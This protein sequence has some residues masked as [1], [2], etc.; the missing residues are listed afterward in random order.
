MPF[1]V[2]SPPSRF[3]VY[4][5]VD[6]LITCDMITENDFVL[7]WEANA[8]DDSLSFVTVEPSALGII[9]E[10][11]ATPNG[12][13]TKVGSATTVTMNWNAGQSRWEPNSEFLLDDGAF[14]LFEVTLAVT[15]K[16]GASC[17]YDVEYPFLYIDLGTVPSASPTISG[18]QQV[19][20]LLTGT[21]NYFSPDGIPQDVP[22]TVRRWYSYTDAGGSIGET[23]IGTGSTYT[24]TSSETN[25]YIRYKVTPAAQSG[26]SPGFEYSSTVFGMVVTNIP[27]YSGSTTSASTFTISQTLASAETIIIDWGDG[28]K[29]VLS[30]TTGSL[31][32]FSRTYAG[33]G[34]KNFFVYETATNVRAVSMFSKSLTGTLDISTCTGINTLFVY[35][36]SALT[37]ISWPVATWSDIRTYGCS[38]T[39]IVF[40][41]GTVWNNTTLWV[42]NSTVT[43]LDL[44]NTTGTMTALVCEGSSITSLD[45][46]TFNFSTVG[47]F[48]VSNSTLL[49]TINH[50][51]TT[52]KVYR[53]WAQNTSIE[54]LTVPFDF[55]NIVAAIR[56]NNNGSLASVNFLGTGTVNEF[57]CSACDLSTLDVSMFTVAASTQFTVRDNPSLSSITH[58][59][60][61]SGAF[62]IYDNSI[63]SLGFYSLGG[64]KFTSNVQAAMNDNAMTAA[65]VNQWLDSMS[66]AGSGEDLLPATGT[67]TIIIGGTN[68]APDSSSGGFDGVAAA[69][70]IS[71][72]GYILTT[73]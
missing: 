4:C 20:E 23:L 28:T 17:S 21:D 30:A 42:S 5:P 7:S 65:E 33:S 15:L 49:A 37:S 39:D 62:R 61:P 54:T 63:C 70:A 38:L 16:S 2:S 9:S 1:R 22:N 60:S 47:Q 14:Y 50:G 55:D 73:T 11:T 56:I 27:A 53:Y 68:A 67:G 58:S 46:S 24:L 43:S 10:I 69:T 25:K 66:S 26:P 45:T 41:V 13:V 31:Q 34:T 36:N 40:P 3:N 71:G 18:F 52:G 35:S 19:G 59:S 44:S 64:A 6:G 32:S 51:S 8:I 57:L 72:G 48:R 12:S 29:N